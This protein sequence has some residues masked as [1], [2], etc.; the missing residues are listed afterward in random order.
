[1][2]RPLVGI[3]ISLCFGIWVARYNDIAFAVLGI[4]AFMSLSACIMLLKRNKGFST[5]FLWAYFFVIGAFLFLH[6]Q[7]L[8]PHHIARYLANKG[9][10]AEVQGVIDNDP[11]AKNSAYGKITT[12]ILNIEKLIIS[13]KTYEVNGKVLVNVYRE[14]NLQYA[15]RL[16]LEGKIYKPMRFEISDKLNYREYLNRKN[17]YGI[18]SVKKR[19]NIQILEH[20]PGNPLKATAYRI[21]KKIKTVIVAYL[22]FT[23]ASLIKAML[24][25]ERQDI[26]SVVKDIFIKTGTVHI[27]AISG[28]HVG[29]VA[30]LIL[31]FLRAIHIPRKVR[32]VLAMMFLIMYVF[33]TGARPSVIRATVMA[34]VL[35]GG[36]LFEREIDIYN[37]L[38]AAGM[39]ILMVNP[40]QLFDIGFQLSF[41]SVLSIIYLYSKLEKPLFRLKTNKAVKFFIRCFCVSSAA[42][43]GVAGLIAYYF[44]IVT[45]I[46]VFANVFIVPFISIVLA[47]SLSFVAFGIVVPKLAFVFAAPLQLALFILVKV[48]DTLHSIPFAYFY[49]GS[50]RVGLVIFYYCALAI[51]VQLILTKPFKYARL[52]H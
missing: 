10:V 32:F 41:V 28:L 19:G 17:V 6:S 8:P 46:S 24:L 3:C 2:R 49:T 23:E 47:L 21:K 31:I 12:F 18:V 1:M 11:V 40:Q 51:G 7:Q 33:M 52:P 44:N 35:L 22:P 38:A 15:D 25:G 43:V 26:P 16:L 42:W 48:A 50:F 45:P 30:F 5:F 20:T 4:G 14:E 37:S 39:L 36:F 29:I 9:R 27:L 34:V 13:N